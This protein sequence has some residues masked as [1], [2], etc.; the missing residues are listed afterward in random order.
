MTDQPDPTYGPSQPWAV[1]EPGL[2]TIEG[3]PGSWPY[4]V[5]EECGKQGPTEVDFVGERYRERCK[6]CHQN[7]IDARTTHLRDNK[8]TPDPVAEALKVHKTLIEFSE[9]DIYSTS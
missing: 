4:R 8:I 6:T 1:N 3:V 2:P 5:C 7:N 9:F